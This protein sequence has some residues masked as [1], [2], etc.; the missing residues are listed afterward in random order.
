MRDLLLVI[1]GPTGVGKTGI[2]VKL[3]RDFNGEIVNA[4]SRQV[5][6]FLDIGTD[7]P[8]PS[9]LEEAPH[10]LISVIDPDDE[11]NLVCYQR[12]A[13]QTISKILSRG[14]LP[15]LVG[16]SGLY[17]WAVVEGWVLPDVP[18][19]TNLRAFCQQKD[20]E[21]LYQELLSA[22]PEL[23][24]RID[25]KNKRRLI[26]ALELIEKGKAEPVRK[27]PFCDSLVIGLTMV[28]SS[29]YRRVDERIE[30]MIRTGLIDEVKGI[31]DMNY[32]PELPALSGI[33][34]RQIIAYL[35]GRLALEEAVKEMKVA[36]HRLIRQ[37]Y[38]WFR[39]DDGRIK[40][41]DLEEEE[42]YSK[43]TT[44]VRESLRR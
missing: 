3:A 1:V 23:A 20:V 7:K 10:H 41:F 9:L 24:A 22:S 19:N 36:T 21:M 8:E 35:Q 14:R 33:G 34:Y 26:R 31:L 5:Y 4:D 28:R 2:A 17:V 32:A 37:Q 39:L 29:L 40:W 25:R 42:V 16:G 43:I 38:N 11:F 12:L 30:R 13:R 6:R 15:I 27:A 18:P 44:F